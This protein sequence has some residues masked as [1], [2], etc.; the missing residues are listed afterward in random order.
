VVLSNSRGPETLSDLVAELG[1]R[2]R[3]AT[4]SEAGEAGDLVVVTVPFKAYLDVPVEP[5][6]GKV[7]IDTN[8]YYFE[9]DGHYAELDE[10]R[11]SVSEMLAA[12]LPTSKVVKAFNA[13]QAAHIVT[14]G[15]PAGAEDRRALAIA[16]DD[17]D[18]KAVVTDLIES[19]GFD[20]VDAGPL[21]EGKR[22]DRDKP[23]YGAELDADGLRE[24]LAAG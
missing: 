6:A 16:G 10:G 8:N 24:A 19:F 14:E 4:A 22:F 5:L 23:A 15:R 18:A 9:R 13:I 3:A 17:A 20:V 12:H 2:A 1:P 21:A 11:T 7:V